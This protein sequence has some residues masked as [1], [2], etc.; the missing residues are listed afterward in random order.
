MHELG[1][2]NS[3]LE[4]VKAEAARHPGARPVKVGLRVGELSGV[5]PDS[6]AF[7]FQAMTSGTEWEPLALEIE[8]CPR[9]HRCPSCLNTFPVAGHDFSCPVCGNPRT[10]CIGGEELDLAYVE[11]EDQ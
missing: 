6:L 5:N 9:R 3:V 11:M 10:H 8:T 2:A 1:I 4:A 7:G